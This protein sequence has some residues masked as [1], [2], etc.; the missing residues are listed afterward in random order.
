MKNLAKLCIFLCLIF[1]V[2]GQNVIPPEIATEIDAL[3]VEA[4]TKQH[5]P[6][7]GISI[8]KGDKANDGPY[9]YVFEKGYG[10]RNIEANENATEHTLFGIGSVTKV[11]N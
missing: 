9:A 8:V 11:N 5:I 6:A 4:I 7:L 1:A 3:I 10:L 2:L